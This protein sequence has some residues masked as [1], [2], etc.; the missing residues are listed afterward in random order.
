MIPPLT[1]QYVQI[2]KNSA[3]VTLIA[4]EDLDIVT[5]KIGHET[6]RA[7]EAATATT[8]VYLTVA[9]FVAGSMSLLQRY[10]ER[11]SA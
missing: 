9:M 7:F 6:Y 10:L 3:I 1:T 2:V 4:L 5:Q 8:V 11:R